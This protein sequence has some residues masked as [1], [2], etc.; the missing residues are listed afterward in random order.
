MCALLCTVCPGLTNLGSPVTAPPNGSYRGLVR[1]A[2]VPVAA[3]R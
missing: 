3:G 2:S 1:K